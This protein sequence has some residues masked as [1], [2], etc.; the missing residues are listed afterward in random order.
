VW[1]FVLNGHVCDRSITIPQTDQSD[2]FLIFM[3]FALNSRVSASNSTT[4]A[5][6][7]MLLQFISRPV[8]H[9]SSLATAE[10]VGDTAFSKCLLTSRYDN[11]LSHLTSPTKQTAPAPAF[12]IYIVSYTSYVELIPHVIYCLM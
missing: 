11:I 5:S 7:R 2:V 3:S 1:R 10:R 12:G 8:T 6:C 4:T 9:C